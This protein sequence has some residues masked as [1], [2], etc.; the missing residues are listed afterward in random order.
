MNEH[1]IKIF[2]ETNNLSPN[3][4]KTFN[5]HHQKFKDIRNIIYMNFTPNS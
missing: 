4:L 1:E 2:G 5:F 3:N